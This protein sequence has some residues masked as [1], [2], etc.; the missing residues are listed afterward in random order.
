[1]SQLP[2]LFLQKPAVTTRSKLGGGG[3][4]YQKPSAADQKARLDARFASIA[5]AFQGL[6]A[7]VAG[8]VPEQVIVVET[9]TQSVDGVAQAASLIPGLEWLA[10]LDL[11]EQMPELGFANLDER[12]APL[13][14][15]LYALMS[16]QSAMIALIDL[17]GQ[18][19]SS[20][21]QRAKK[22]F[23]PFKNLFTLLKDI[24]HW[25]AE[26]RVRETG[27]LD[28]WREHI[29]IGATMMFEV[30][31][32]FRAD[33]TVREGALSD[34]RESIGQVGGT[35]VAH[36]AIEQIQYHAALVEVPGT[37][38]RQFL[39]EVEQG[40]YSA[41]LRS[42]GVMFFRPRA[43]SAF[44]MAPDEAV[45]FELQTRLTDQAEPGGPS[46]VA[47]FD[48][49]PVTQH[50]ALAS[51]LV[52]DDPDDHAQHYGANQ[53]HHG[54]AMASAIIHGDLHETGPALRSPVYVRPIFI[55]DSF[56]GRTEITPP[57]V[58]LVDLVHRAFLRLFVGTTNE[59]A[60]AS[61]VRVVNLSLGDPHQPFDRMLSP[62]A[63]LL[64]WLAWRFR[65]LIVVSVG[66]HNNVPIEL[67]PQWA[68]WPRRELSAQVLRSMQSSQVRRRPLSPAEAINCLSV[69]STH[70]DGSGAFTLGDRIDLTGDAVLPSPLGT[71]AQGFR[72]ATKPE[73]MFPGGRLLHRAAPGGGNKTTFNAVDTTLAPGVLTAAAGVAPME[74]GR[75]KYSCGTSNAAALATRCAAIA[76]QVL[77][78]SLIPEDSEPLVPELVAV[79][80][81]ALVVHGASWIEAGP[82]I[83][84]AF[85]EAA[86]DW[87]RLSRLKQQFLGYGPVDPARCVGGSERRATVLAWGHIAREQAHSYKLPLPPSLASST[88]LRRVTATL[89]WFTP[90]NH[91]H[92]N[93]RRAQMWLDLNDVEL[94][95]GVRGLDAQA[96]RR[97]T[98]E[99]RICEGRHAVPFTEGATMDIRVN[100]KDDA[101]KLDVT[102]PYAIAI[103]IE[104]GVNSMTDVYNEI[105]QRIRPAVTI[106][107]GR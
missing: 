66:N 40:S 98:V 29:D 56:G 86:G 52:V 74:L 83:E 6:Q 101:G 33:G 9:L 14:R 55:P 38:I 81:K 19:T 10:E 16:N 5:Q 94:A 58:L 34:L 13:P 90:A 45:D 17:W 48:G 7:N 104:V 18:W 42:E 22:G 26:D 23:G 27:I 61:S 31:F 63:K 49:L 103:S 35:I 102:V 60:I 84:R 2:F 53:R 75:V 72:R 64:D 100:C 20:P 88:E 73:V 99:H 65:V 77:N 39:R 24:R 44:G 4:R 67:D 68:T 37:A 1:M 96:A 12:G 89:A 32:W 97:G 25:S 70:A 78:A 91:R 41:V 71:V 3:A 54:T 59:P 21:E 46:V 43:Q 79:V 82:A 28:R 76:H 57:R 107:A 92:Q 30:E 69:G 87:R 47:L 8:L 80:L 95:Q 50:T 62:L 106:V 93:Y 51:R 85:P 36:A 11:D 105:Q 15:R